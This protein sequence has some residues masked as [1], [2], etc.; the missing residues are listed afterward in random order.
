MYDLCLLND[1]LVEIV[2]KRKHEY[3]VEGKVTNIFVG[4]FTIACAR[5]E[6][7]N[8]L[9]LLGENVLYVDTD[10][11]VCFQTHGPQTCNRRFPRGSYK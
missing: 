3:A 9:D 4:I 8:L 2:F 1:D 7:Y 6:L 11:C 5:L 10:S